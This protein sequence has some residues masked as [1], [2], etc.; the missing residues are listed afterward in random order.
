ML[1]GAKGD[2]GQDAET[3]FTHVVFA[4]AADGTGF[5]QDVTEWT[6]NH[7]YLAVL[8]TT[9]PAE[10]LVA[11]DF[12]GLWIKFIIDSADNIKIA[13]KGSYF[14]SDNVEAALQELGNILFG[15]EEF[16]KEV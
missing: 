16:L 14:A 4:T 1:T 3:W 7:K 15:L 9:K 13:D 12:A 11:G 2:P 8:T 10:S 5:I 6:N